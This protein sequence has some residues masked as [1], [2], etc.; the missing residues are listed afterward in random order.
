MISTLEKVGDMSLDASSHSQILFDWDKFPIDSDDF[1]EF[2][3]S[4]AKVQS[5]VDDDITKN[6]D[7]A[8]CIKSLKEFI[9]SFQSSDDEVV[10]PLPQEAHH[11]FMK[12]MSDKY[13]SLE[14]DV[15]GDDGRLFV[16]IFPAPNHGTIIFYR[17]I[18]GMYLFFIRGDK[19]AIVTDIGCHPT[20]VSS[21]LK[22]VNS[23]GSYSMPINDPF[24][25]G[26]WNSK[27]SGKLR[28]LGPV[29]KN[30]ANSFVIEPIS[31]QAKLHPA[32]PF[33]DHMKF[34]EPC[35]YNDMIL[36]D[37]KSYATMTAQELVNVGIRCVN[38]F[39]QDLHH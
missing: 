5:F 11:D 34:D 7:A 20:I 15:F 4:S 2:F 18:D 30:D 16:S 28:P 36:M 39:T 1:D 31:Q 23:D 8:D 32:C 35:D 33:G 25:N 9:Q 22:Y 14:D 12:R 6:V 3:P 27:I 21:F 10:F 24:R 38:E 17:A 26:L 29:Y 13:F 19:A 37:R